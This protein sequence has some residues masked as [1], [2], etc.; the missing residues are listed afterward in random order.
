MKR[1]I[2]LFA[3]I[4]A[5]ALLLAGMSAVAETTI[6]VQ[7]GG[8][9]K[10]D[11]DR[12][13]ISLGVREIAGDVMTAQSAVNE[14]IAAVVDALKEMGVGADAISTNGIGIYPNYS[15]DEVESI[16][17]Y[18]AYNN[19]YLTLA[20]VNNTGAYIDAAFAAGANSLDEVEFSATDTEEAAQK[21]LALAVDS[22]K[23]K[24]RVLADAA[25]LKLGAILEIRE[26]D[27]LGYDPN[28]L[29]AKNEASMD[30]GAGTEVLASKQTVSA[31]VVVTFAAGE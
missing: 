21:A 2:R 28:A 13:S 17:G 25:G 24:A 12:V 14:K 6:T 11:A 22:A 30:A 15:Y 10:V 20:D 27:S 26:G 23:E 3:M 29:Y 5:A 9:V 1:N 7:G 8:N 19:I 4:V 31:T 18:T 16:N